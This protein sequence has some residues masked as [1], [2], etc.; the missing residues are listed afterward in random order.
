MKEKV[1]FYWDLIERTLWTGI[2]TFGGSEIVE[3]WFL[4][5]RDMP[6][7]IQFKIALGAAGLA[8]LKGIASTKLP[9]A[10]ENTASSLPKTVEP[11]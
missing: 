7:N 11:G 1:K 6:T 9:W 5:N 8:M 3:N 2:Q 10:K 4:G